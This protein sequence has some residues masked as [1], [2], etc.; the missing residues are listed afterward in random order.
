MPWVIDEGDARLNEDG[1][2]SVRVKGLVFDP[3]DPIVV[4]KDR[5]GIN[6]VG[7]FR[8]ILSCHESRPPAESRP[9]TGIRAVVPLP[10][11]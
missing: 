6:T 10:L 1:T 2:L 3:N 8:A 4:S 7:K 9:A 11:R 5:D